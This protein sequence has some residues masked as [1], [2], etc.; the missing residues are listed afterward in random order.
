MPER[1]SIEVDYERYA[2]MLDASDL[3]EDQK[4]EFLET[5]WQVI[6]QFVDLGFGVHPLQAVQSDDLTDSFNAEDRSG[7]DIGT[8]VAKAIGTNMTTENEKEVPCTVEHQ[9]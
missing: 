9:T 7:G 3:N 2:K 6:V 8:A 5:L 4:R 1:P